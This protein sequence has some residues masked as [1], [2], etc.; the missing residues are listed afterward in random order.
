MSVWGDW[1]LGIK[2]R[3]YRWLWG[4]GSQAGSQPGR[5]KAEG[6]L[7]GNTNSRQWC[8]QVSR[9]VEGVID[10]PRILS[11]WG[12]TGKLHT[13]AS[14]WS[15][16]DA[17]CVLFDSFVI[18]SRGNDWLVSS[19]LKLTI[20]LIHFITSRTDPEEELQQQ[21][22]SP[23]REKVF[24]TLSTLQPHCPRR[25]QRLSSFLLLRQ[26]LAWSLHLQ[27]LQWGP[28]FRTD[29][30]IRTWKSGLF[31]DQFRIRIKSWIQ[32]LIASPDF[33]KPCICRITPTTLVRVSSPS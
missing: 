25:T 7:L 21:H 2:Y 28:E 19:L 11:G 14:K 29:L 23:A 15:M 17:E 24:P 8:K 33:C 20:I 10:R 4:K 6:K 12:D 32:D 3:W 31:Q 5:Q 1:W 18:L 9:Q 26:L 16:L 13:D 27:G 22:D 30:E